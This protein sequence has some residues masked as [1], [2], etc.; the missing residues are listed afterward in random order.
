MSSRR[1]LK[2][3]EGQTKLKGL[4]KDDTTN[5]SAKQH[6]TFIERFIHYFASG[7][8]NPCPYF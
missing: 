4:I 3:E 6:V 1:K 8:M 7:F 5:K 2:K